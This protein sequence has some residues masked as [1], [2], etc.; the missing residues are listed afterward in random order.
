M[1][2]TASIICPYCGE[3]IEV[4]VDCSQPVQTYIEDCAVCCRPIT[5]DITIDADLLPQVSPRHENE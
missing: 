2:E 5:L 1:L 4:L 3:N